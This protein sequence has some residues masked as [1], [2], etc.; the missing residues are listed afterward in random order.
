MSL[1][2]SACRHYNSKLSEHGLLCAAAL[3][4][5]ITVGY[6]ISD[7]S[8]VRSRVFGAG[9]VNMNN[10]ARGDITPNSFM[11]S[12]TV[13]IVSEESEPKFCVCLQG[14]VQAKFKCK[15]TRKKTMF[16]LSQQPT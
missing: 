3:T 14:S 13:N 12:S 11:L 15:E 9:L 2:P 16:F 7:T 4:M 8:G 10:R 5:L 1:P 6:V